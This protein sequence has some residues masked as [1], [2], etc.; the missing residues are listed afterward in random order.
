[1]NADR[2]PE[3]DAGGNAGIELNQTWDMDGWSI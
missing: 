2:T 1:M 3:S